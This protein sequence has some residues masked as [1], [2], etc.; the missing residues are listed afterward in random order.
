MKKLSLQEKQIFAGELEM[1]LSSGLGIEEG[2][3]I[4]AQELPSQALKETVQ[5]MIETFAQEGTFYAA[6]LQ[7]QAFDPYMEQMVRMGN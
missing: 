6:V 3:Q 4:I 1:I 5:S 2:L 7:T